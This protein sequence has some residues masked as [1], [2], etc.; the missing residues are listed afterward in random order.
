[1]KVNLNGK[2]FIVKWRHPVLESGIRITEC[3]VK[4]E[5][6]SETVASTRCSKKEQFQK[7]RGRK[8]SLAR[9]LK[10]MRLPKQERKFFWVEYL[11]LKKSLIEA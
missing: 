9:V 8:I 3:S 5:G 7:D 6:W 10:E 1:M 2:V 4:A 11:S